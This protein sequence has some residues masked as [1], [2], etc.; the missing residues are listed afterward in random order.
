MRVD[1][2]LNLLKPPGMT[3]H[4]VV[5]FARRLLGQRRVGH[6]GTLDPAAAGVLPL[7]LGR[8]TRL[9]PL[10]G[11]EK[12]YRAEVCLGATTTTLDAEGAVTAFGDA[13]RVT[14]A[15]VTAALAR[16]EGEVEQRPPPYSAAHVGGRRLHE[17]AR[18]GRQMEGRPR[19]V[20]IHR[21]ELTGFW[22]GR[23]ARALLAIECGPGTYVRVLAGELGRVLGCGA[24]LS[25]LVRTRVGRFA[26]P[27]ALT[28]EEFRERA[29]TGHFD[30]AV[31]PPDW[32]LVH[33]PATALDDDAAWAFLHGAAAMVAGCPTGLV[34]AYSADGRFLGVGAV[35]EEAEL[36]PRVVVREG[37]AA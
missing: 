23:A 6:L 11:G 9:S 24:Y 34:R 12:E 4:D 31:L 19:R 21:L 2:F 30:R 29:E 27:E 16:F 35:S 33:L 17:L 25:F 26:L 20:R 18:E 1:G 13:S 36:R 5:V 10:A 22:P 37:V 7:A 28:L 14:R 3:S 32:P 15:E 8:A